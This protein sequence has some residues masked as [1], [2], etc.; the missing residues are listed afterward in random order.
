[1]IANFAHRRLSDSDAIKVCREI[2]KS[3]EEQASN[4]P[5]EIKVTVVRGGRARWSTRS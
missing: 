3:I 1:M 5:G 2:A 4:Y